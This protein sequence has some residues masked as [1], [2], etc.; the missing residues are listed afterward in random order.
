MYCEYVWVI[1]CAYRWHSLFCF[2]VSTVDSAKFCVDWGNWSNYSNS[3]NS[4]NSCN[5]STD[6]QKYRCCVELSNNLLQ[7]FPTV[8]IQL[9][10]LLMLYVVFGRNVDIFAGNCII[11]AKLIDYKF[12]QYYK[13]IE[14]RFASH[15]GHDVETAQQQK[16][17][18]N[19][20]NVLLC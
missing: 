16:K 14:T 6:I 2:S 9:I 12:I 7:N 3:S 13:S 1:S 11:H 18:G 4:S 17:R 19:S 20:N 5:W 10:L 8:S 15:F